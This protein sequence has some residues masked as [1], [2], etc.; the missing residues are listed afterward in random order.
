VK[1][2]LYE[3]TMHVL[4]A[5]YYLLETHFKGGERCPPERDKMKLKVRDR[6]KFRQPT[7]WSAVRCI[8]PRRQ[9]SHGIDRTERSSAWIEH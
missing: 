6:Q 7:G 4:L 5:D 3:S 1:L 2:A 8:R 9:A